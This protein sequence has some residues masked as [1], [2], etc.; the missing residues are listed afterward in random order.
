MVAK[1][2]RMRLASRSLEAALYTAWRRTVRF[3][4][5]Y[6]VDLHHF[7]S[8]LAAA[9]DQRDLR[10]GCRDVQAAIE[11]KGARSPIMAEAH[12]GS[13]MKPVRGLSLYFPP[14]RDASVFYREL[15]FAR[16]T[17]WADFLE[18]YLGRAV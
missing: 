10:Q 17:R 8:N 2:V 3:F 13:R 14:F 9:T 11:G 6:Y 5:N 18:A 4:D 15:D 1:A 16:R 7:A 12:L